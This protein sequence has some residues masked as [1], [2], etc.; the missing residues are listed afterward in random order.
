LPT[1]CDERIRSKKALNMNTKFTIYGWRNSKPIVRMDSYHRRAFF[2]VHHRESVN[3]K[4]LYQA[5]L[6]DT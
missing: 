5:P 6:L 3:F 2:R 1:V 4:T